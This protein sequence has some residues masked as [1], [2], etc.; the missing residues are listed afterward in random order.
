MSTDPTGPGHRN[1]PS[2]R[3]TSVSALVVAA[4]AAAAG[5][6]LLIGYSFYQLTPLPWTGAAVL[7]VLA[8]VEAYLAQNT[9]ARI[10]RKRGAPPVQPLAVVRFVALA[11]ASALVGA[12]SAGFAAGLL[13]WL[14]VEPT[15]AARDDVPAAAATLI[16]AIVLIGAALWLE[17]ACRVPERDD[18]EDDD[19][20]R[21]SGR[22]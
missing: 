8:L 19:T 20:G 17:R 6:W 2:L 14:L 9:T 7:F 3:P 10:Q 12:L 11:K 18:R 21:R 1:D 16:G 13:A 15:T 22:L 4:L 5:G